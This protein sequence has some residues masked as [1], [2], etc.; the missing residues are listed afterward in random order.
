MNKVSV[1]IEKTNRQEHFVLL[2]FINEAEYCL[3]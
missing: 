1:Y 2:D 3:F